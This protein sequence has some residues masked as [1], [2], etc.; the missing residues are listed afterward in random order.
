MNPLHYAL[1]VT[2]ALIASPA[3]GQ[4]TTNWQVEP[5][6]DFSVR[7]SKPPRTVQFGG[8]PAQHFVEQIQLQLSAGRLSRL[9][10]ST[11]VEA[12]HHWYNSENA[13]LYVDKKAGGKSTIETQRR[14]RHLNGANLTAIVMT[15]DASAAQSDL[16]L[17]VTDF[18]TFGK[19][20]LQRKDMM[21]SL[22]E[23]TSILK[24][25]KLQDAS[26]D[27]WTACR[28]MTVNGNEIMR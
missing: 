7:C 12:P 6:P 1:L 20:E 4:P 15:L 2:A 13:V 17:L 21:V 28:L 8:L 24:D 14:Y 23:T 11:S 10:Y 19:W 22:K 18:I 26:A 25:G 9:R 27:Y 3:F 16:D 5:E